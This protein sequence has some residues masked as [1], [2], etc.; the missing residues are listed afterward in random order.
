METFRIASLQALHLVHLEEQNSHWG[1]PNA[2][3]SVWTYV[4]RFMQRCLRINRA[5]I[6]EMQYRPKLMEK[7][8][9]FHILYW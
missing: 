5:S 9:E 6:L 4:V 1:T 2:Q 8:K 7:P 3:S